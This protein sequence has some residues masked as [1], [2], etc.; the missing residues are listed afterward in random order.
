MINGTE[1]RTIKVL[2]VENDAEDVNLLREALSEVS[3]VHIELTIIETLDE[4]LQ[5]LCL[6]EKCFDVVLS[7]LFLPDSE[8]VETFV[9][10]YTQIPEIPIIVLVS[11]DD[12]LRAMQVLQEGA[13][14]FLIKGQVDG[15]WL[16][17]ALRYAIER[18]RMLQ[19]Y[20]RPKETS[21]LAS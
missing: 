20:V 3:S 12:E 17:R 21:V 1:N 2:L 9:K 5:C 18:H 7:G 10:L 6:G 11:L 16:I 19:R 15:K 8:G 14:D 4:A 13:Q